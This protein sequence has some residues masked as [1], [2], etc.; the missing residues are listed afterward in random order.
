[1]SMNQGRH[2]IASRLEH[3]PEQ[4]RFIMEDQNPESIAMLLPMCVGLIAENLALKKA[5]RACLTGNPPPDIKVYLKEQTQSESLS[6]LVAIED[7]AGGEVALILQRAI[8]E[9]DL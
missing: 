6:L 9:F 7:K 5:L 3:S 4:Y 1:M 8:R 2:Q